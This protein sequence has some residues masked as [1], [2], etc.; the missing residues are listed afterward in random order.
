MTTKEHKVFPPDFRVTLR[1]LVGVHQS[2]Y[3]LIPPQ[4]IYFEALVE[5]A[6]RRIK[7]PFDIVKAGGRNQPRHDLLVENTR[8]SIKTET[9]NNTKPNQITITKLC[10]TEREPWEPKVLIGR[11][12]EHLSRYDVVLMF[13]AV[14]T[15][16]AIRYQL[17]EISVEILRRIGDVTLEPVGRRE[18][19]QSL[20]TDVLWHGEKVFRV[21]FDA[22]DGK[23]SVRGLG[24]QHCEML[25]EWDVRR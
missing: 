1:G 24:L 22:S 2:I 20:G 10:T 19:R 15:E 13:R 8:I 25:E 14:W 6:F 21:H 4:G 18:G 23:C 3:P 12:M 16:K 5:E 11:V 7:K 17:V 9:G